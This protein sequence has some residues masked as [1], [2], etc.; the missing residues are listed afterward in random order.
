MHPNPAFRG[1]EAAQNLA[2]AKERGFGVLTL[3]GPDGPVASHLPFV[4]DEA[5]GVLSA[6]I[7]KSNPIW[8]ILRAGAA[9]ALMVVSGPDGYVSPD[10]Y[11]E[12]EQVPTWN[13]VAVHLSGSLRLLDDEVMRPHVDAL[14]S[15]FEARLAPKPVWTAEKMSEEALTR[16]MRML[17]PIELAVEAIEGTWKL[18]QNKSEAARRGAAASIG[19]SP[20]G[21]N[22]TELAAHMAD[23]PA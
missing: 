15:E 18:N 6:H 20:I 3:A 21:T 16:M 9:P 2:F 7:V 1:A 22:L 5:K 19:T 14:S 13:Y 11:G 12:P 8:R 4:M 10:W 23:P 17:A